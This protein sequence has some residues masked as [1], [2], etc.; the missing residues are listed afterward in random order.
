MNGMLGDAIEDE[1][2]P[3]PSVTRLEDVD[4]DAE[5]LDLAGL[6]NRLSVESREQTHQETAPAQQSV[7]GQVD[8]T[9]PGKTDES[10][11]DWTPTDSD[12]D[13]ETALAGIDARLDHIESAVTD[14]G[15]EAR[16]VEARVVDAGDGTLLLRLEDPPEDL[17]HGQRL[18]VV[19][20]S[21]RGSDVSDD[22]AD[23]D[24]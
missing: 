6:R 23:Q 17:E 11:T 22:L 13:I 24:S 20:P 9:G 2:I 15:V 3:L 21:R 12:P 8:A 1:E 10:T 16:G 5:G 7:D 14:R 4:L 19:L 18:R